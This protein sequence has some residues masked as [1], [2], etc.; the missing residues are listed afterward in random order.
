MFLVFDGS[1]L[2]LQSQV[3][4]EPSQA[5]GHIGRVWIMGR[6]YLSGIPEPRGCR[7]PHRRT[8][9]VCGVVASAEYEPKEQS[10]PTLLDLGKTYRI[11]H[12]PRSSRAIIDRNSGPSRPPFAASASGVTGKISDYHG[13]PEIAL[14]DPVQRF[15]RTDS[16]RVV[17]PRLIA[18]GAFTLDG[19]VRIRHRHPDQLGGLDLQHRGELGDDLTAQVKRRVMR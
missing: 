10:Q 16:G 12:S 7:R 11:P 13:K 3:R 17:D 19:G 18:A 9:T 6:L 14:T 2:A 5:A 1:L 4:N 8:A 15:S